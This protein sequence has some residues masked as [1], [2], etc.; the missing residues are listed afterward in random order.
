MIPMDEIRQFLPTARI[1]GD[2]FVAD[3]G[4]WKVHFK[5]PY[6]SRGWRCYVVLPDPEPS[7][8]LEAGYAEGV[9]AE[10]AFFAAVDVA[11][12]FVAT[13]SE[14]SKCLVV[15]KRIKQRKQASEG[16]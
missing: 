9:T 10:E 7:K 1:V 6:H 8:S 5:Y 3:V 11:L 15:L 14:A 12:Q 4:E 13:L 2:S 16:R